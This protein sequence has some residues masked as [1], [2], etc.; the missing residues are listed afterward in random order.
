MP[1]QTTLGVIWDT[2]TNEMF[3]KRPDFSLGME[4]ALTKRQIVS[5]QHQ[6]FDPLSW[7][8][9]FY[10][11]MNLCCS[12]IVREVDSWDTKVLLDSLLL[13]YSSFSEGFHVL[14]KLRISLS[15]LCLF[16][17]FYRVK[18]VASSRAGKYSSEIFHFIVLFH[19]IICIIIVVIVISNS[20]VSLLILVYYPNKIPAVSTGRK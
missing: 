17:A 7:W 3:I 4:R 1:M 6:I 5:L 15:R 12:K 10:V 19:I 11:R 20:F 13:N 16:P 8:A 9:P 18:V 2:T 14:A